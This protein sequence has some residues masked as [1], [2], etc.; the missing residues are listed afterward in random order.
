M[1][2]ALLATALSG[3]DASAQYRFTDLGTF[4]GAGS[5]YAS[6]INSGGQVVGWFDLGSGSAGGAFLYSNGTMQKLDSLGA[7]AA[8]NGINDNG[9][10]VGSLNASTGAFQ[11]ILYASGSVQDLGSFFG[12]AESD[13]L[14]VNDSGE[15]VG[16]SLGNAGGAFLYSNGAMTNLGGVLGYDSSANAINNLGQIAGNYGYNGDGFLYTNGAVTVISYDGVVI[17]NAIND[18]GRVAG[19]MAT[20][21]GE[22]AF[23]WSAGAGM[24]DLGT[25]PAPLNTGSEAL[26]INSGGQI[27][28]SSWNLSYI[29]PNN[30]PL[31]TYHAFVYSNG[32]MEDLNN[33]TSVPAG[34]TLWQATAINASGQIVGYGVINSTYQDF[35]FLLTPL[36]PGD[37]NGDGQVDINDLTIVLANFGQTGTTWSQGDF[38]GDGTVDID[39]L[40]IVLTNFGYGVGAAS[41][42]RVPEPSALALLALAACATGFA[43]AM[44]GFFSGMRASTSRPPGGTLEGKG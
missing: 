38:T 33:L 40:T 14:G 29:G 44:G 10:V 41:P 21:S 43:S 18:A 9:A 23:L 16:V 26:G 15:V 27:V 1:I 17:P 13:A 31:Y 22:H 3:P 7:G 8:A 39:D 34:L 37:A 32:T 25:L 12:A 35:A 42:A 11:A 5:S 4:P 30:L 28:G 24:T 2:G 36:E 20:P 19:E 6:G